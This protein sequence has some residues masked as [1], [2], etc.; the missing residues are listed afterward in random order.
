MTSTALS[1]WKCSATVNGFSLV[2]FNSV[3]QLRPT[4][5]NPMDCSTPGF[6][7][8][9]QLP[10]LTQ[11][12]VHWAGDAIQQ[13]HSLSSPS[14]PALNLSQHQGLFK[15][16]SSLHQV[17]K[18]LEFR[19]QHQSSQWVFRIDLLYNW[20]VSSPCPRDSQESSPALQFEASILCHTALFTVQHSHPYMT[21]GKIIALTI[22]PLLAKW[23]L[24][25]LRCCLGW[26]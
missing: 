8:H 21:T 22:R 15:W 25:F 11:T 6:P 3:A 5:C 10:E 16:V 2:Q 1:F 19:L 13:S 12:H 18:A 4:L 14:F 7:I 24:C 9:H 23:C 20:L 26:S 17:A